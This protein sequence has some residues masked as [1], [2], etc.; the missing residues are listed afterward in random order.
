[1]TDP[2]LSTV[3]ETLASALRPLKASFTREQIRAI[4]TACLLVGKV[5]VG[6]TATPV[7]DKVIA[8]LEDFSRSEQMERLI[9]LVL[10]LLQEDVET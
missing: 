9:D 6:W 10:N 8:W 3:A 2:R 1:M 4:I 7:D 5:V